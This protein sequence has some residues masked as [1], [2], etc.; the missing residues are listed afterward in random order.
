MSNQV[1]ITSWVLLALALASWASVGYAAHL[2]SETA[3]QRS[4]DTRLALTKANQVALNQRVEA[5]A[6]NTKEKRKQLETIAGADVVSV[7][8]IID[9][10]GK[11]A[12]I[13]A[14]VSDAA[15]ASSLQLGKTTDTLRGLVFNVQG[16]GTFAEVMHAAALYEKL[17]LLSSID[18]IDIE[19]QPSPDPKLPPWHIN[20]R[21]RVQTLISVS[22]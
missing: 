1:K 13:E 20:A 14:K 9:A 3:T 6:E 22:I 21:I 12:G 15:V 16:S 4:N 5:L 18:Q 2:I 8:D 11:S 19:K 17:P 10:A 7:I